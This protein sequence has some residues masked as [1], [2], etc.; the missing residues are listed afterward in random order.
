M[1]KVK[2]SFVL[3][4]LAVLG[5]QCKKQQT[6][7]PCNGQLPF[8]TDFG[9]Y[10]RMP[11]SKAF[12]GD[13]LI[14]LKDG[15]ISL[16]GYIKFA[17]KTGTTFSSSFDSLRWMVGNS[18]NVSTQN[19][20]QLAFG[21]PESNIQVQLTGYKRSSPLNC[22][23]D[24]PNVQIVKKTIS[25]VAPGNSIPIVGQFHGYNT[26]NPTDTFTISVRFESARNWLVVKNFPKGNMGY[27]YGILPPPIEAYVGIAPNSYGY[28]FILID[29]ENGSI[30]TPEYGPLY[31][32]A[33]VVD[34]NRMEIGYQQFMGKDTEGRWI[35]AKQ[36]Q[37]IGIR[38]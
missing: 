14:E 27:P 26:D 16:G 21:Q 22:F 24:V 2:T 10:Q 13:T 28:N 7:A 5:L 25:I 37:F 12:N 30:G 36:R 35:N 33:K 9:I 3:L 18:Q 15:D 34:G 1:Y 38:K 8:K 23:P 32:I 6:D 20:Y 19:E 31:G 11:Y 29:N 4:V 17:V